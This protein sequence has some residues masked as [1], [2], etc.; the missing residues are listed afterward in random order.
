VSLLTPIQAALNEASP[1]A[2]PVP[3]KSSLLKP[4]CLITA[5]PAMFVG[6]VRRRL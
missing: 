5:K 6:N 2:V 1:P 3:R 4:F